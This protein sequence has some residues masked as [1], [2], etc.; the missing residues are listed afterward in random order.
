L[1]KKQTPRPDGL[2]CPRGL[3]DGYKSHRLRCARSGIDFAIATA[4]VNVADEKK[5]LGRVAEGFML[6]G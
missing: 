4:I 5:P 6:Y 1:E 2:E 3:K